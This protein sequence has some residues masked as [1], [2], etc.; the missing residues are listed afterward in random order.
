VVEPRGDRGG[1]RDAG[2]RG[3]GRRVRGGKR[4]RE[5][6][7]RCGE[8]ADYSEIDFHSPFPWVVGIDGTITATVELVG[9]YDRG[10]VT[11]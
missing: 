8:Q 7:E 11:H 9:E 6:R 5:D 4:E 10:P 3:G 1:Q 2:G